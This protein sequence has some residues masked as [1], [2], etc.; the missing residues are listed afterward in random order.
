MSG[1]RGR[2]WIDE[3]LPGV[4]V[5]RRYERA[6]LRPDLT[7]GVALF[8]LVIPAGMACS[9][10]YKVSDV[11][12]NPHTAA[13]GS[14][15]EIDYPGIGPVKSANNPIKLSDAPVETRRKSPT[16]GEHTV[17]IMREVGYS[18][19]EIATLREAKA[20]ATA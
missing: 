8:A 19:E 4:S 15:L 14:V 18:D 9:A 1:S 11:V 5:A 2:G 6:W 3:L 20:I 7:A 13:R 16:V 17:E 10:A 12:K